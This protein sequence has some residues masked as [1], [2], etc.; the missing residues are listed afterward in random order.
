MWHVIAY[1][2]PRFCVKPRPFSPALTCVL[3]VDRPSCIQ[4]VS[5]SCG[6]FLAF[7]PGVF[8]VPLLCWESL[9]YFVIKSSLFVQFLPSLVLHLGP[10]LHTHYVAASQNVRALKLYF[11]TKSNC[12]YFNITSGFAENKTKHSRAF[13]Y[14]KRV[15]K[16][17]REYEIWPLRFGSFDTCFFTVG[18]I[19][20]IAFEGS[21]IYLHCTLLSKARNMICI[22]HMSSFHLLLCLS[23]LSTDVYLG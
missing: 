16:Q 18:I 15:S 3:L 22:W 19:A 2:F 20:V 9:G 5:L 11:D 23:S 4:S 1:D 14:F 7:D 13:I 17:Q 21:L 8:A 10:I 6:L 12:L